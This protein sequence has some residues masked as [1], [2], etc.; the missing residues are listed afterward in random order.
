MKCILV[1]FLF[2]NIKVIIL[3]YVNF[4]ESRDI[5]IYFI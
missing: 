4:M 1:G 3:N 5:Y 2:F